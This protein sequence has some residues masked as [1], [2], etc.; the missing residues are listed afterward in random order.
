[1]CEVWLRCSF[2]VLTDSFWSQRI[3]L[4]LCHRLHSLCFSLSN[5]ATAGLSGGYGWRKIVNFQTLPLVMPPR[6]PR[7]EKAQRKGA[8]FAVGLWRSFDVN[9]E[10]R[11]CRPMQCPLI[12]KTYNL[13]LF[14]ASDHSAGRDG[15]GIKQ[16]PAMLQPRGSPTNAGSSERTVST[17]EHAFRCFVPTCSCS[18][19]FLHGPFVPSASLLLFV[20]GSFNPDMQKR[21]CVDFVD[22]LIDQSLDNWRTRWYDKYQRCALGIAY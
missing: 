15:H 22:N 3:V 13:I 20:F 4:S 7:G 8:W 12:I 1:V 10:P 21:Q 17:I 14:G 11:R 2:L 6:I 9:G 16:G 19:C 18:C 5:V